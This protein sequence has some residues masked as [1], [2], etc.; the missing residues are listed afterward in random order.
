MVE[1]SDK[2]E[3]SF[4]IK[5]DIF[6]EFVEIPMELRPESTEEYEEMRQTIK[7][8]FTSIHQVG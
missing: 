6:G 7:R 1:L 5:K 4:R 8:L 2:P 3:E